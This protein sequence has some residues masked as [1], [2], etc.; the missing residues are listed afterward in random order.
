MKKLT[1]TLFVGDKQIETLSPKQ[2]EDIA[3]R[4]SANL[5]AYYTANPSQYQKLHKGEK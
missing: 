1:V 5:S 4:L 3:K 2:R